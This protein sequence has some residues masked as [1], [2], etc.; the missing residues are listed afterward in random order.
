MSYKV[1]R[2]V[3]LKNG[4]FFDILEQSNCLALMPSRHCPVDVV[5]ENMRVSLRVRAL[6]TGRPSRPTLPAQQADGPFPEP[7]GQNI[8]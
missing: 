6:G 4:S 3:H 5:T 2:W 8:T 1:L 7:A